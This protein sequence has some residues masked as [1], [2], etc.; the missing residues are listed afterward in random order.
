MTDNGETWCFVSSLRY[1]T[2]WLRIQ[3][4]RTPDD[5]I[6]RRD[7]SAEVIGICAL[8]ARNT[9]NSYKKLTRD[10]YLLQQF[11]VSENT[12]RRSDSQYETQRQFILISFLI[13]NTVYIYRVHANSLRRY[14]LQR[15]LAA[16]YL[17]D[18][19]LHLIL[20][21]SPYQIFLDVYHVTRLPP[22]C[23]RM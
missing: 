6:T 21:Y 11:K 23:N 3:I 2:P 1:R 19:T 13:S 4:N 9:L 8:S 12:L 17:C 22:R 10:L 5:D 20:F 18:R 7:L 16:G 14:F 15:N